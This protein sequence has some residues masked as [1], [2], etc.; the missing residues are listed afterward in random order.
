[1]KHDHFKAAVD[2]LNAGAEIPAVVPSVIE[3]MWE[4]ISPMPWE[5][6][7]GMTCGFG[8][9][10][11]EEPTDMPENPDQQFAVMMRFGLLDA[12]IERGIL[13][14]YMGDESRRKRVFATAAS[15][16]CNKD[17]FCEATFVRYL[18]DC[19]PDVAQQIT[20]EITEAGFDLDRPRVGEKFKQWMCDNCC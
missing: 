20:Q 15:F 6:R 10:A 19:P 3:R 9:S 13:D 16:P 4:L 17:D 5:Q 12:L 14:D 2:R 8:P 11:P 18:R 7:T 1:M